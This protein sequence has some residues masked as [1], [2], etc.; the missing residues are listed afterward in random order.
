MITLCELVSAVP[1]LVMQDFELEQQHIFLLDER[2]DKDENALCIFNILVYLTIGV[3]KL[4]FKQ[5]QN[6]YIV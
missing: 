3:S 5:Y 2:Y 4:Q 6:Q 1:N